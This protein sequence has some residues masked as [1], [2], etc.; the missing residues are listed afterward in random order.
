M[1][2]DL[3]AVRTEEPHAVVLERKC[4]AVARPDRRLRYCKPAVPAPPPHDA[5]ILVRV[6]HREHLGMALPAW[7]TVTT[8]ALDAAT[9]AAQ[10]RENLGL[11][12]LPESLLVEVGTLKTAP[13]AAV[14]LDLARLALVPLARP[15][16]RH[17]AGIPLLP[18][19]TDETLAIVAD[20][21][22]RA[23][24]PPAA[25]TAEGRIALR[26][27]CPAV[28]RAPWSLHHAGDA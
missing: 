12:A 24:R 21:M 23:A 28:A 17:P 19:G 10:R 14:R 27:M 2:N 5:P 4:T 11:I 13:S 6:L 1:R 20:G 26:L 3:M 7:A 15:P 8:V 25:P 9:D 22:V 16:S 18:L